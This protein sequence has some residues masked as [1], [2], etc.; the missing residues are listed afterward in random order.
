MK[1]TRNYE[2]WRGD[3]SDQEVFK[4]LEKAKKAFKKYFLLTF[5]PIISIFAIGRAIYCYNNYIFIKTKGRGKGS[6]LVRCW[7]GLGVI[8]NLFIPLIFEKILEN[9]ETRGR[10]VLGFDKL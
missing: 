8:G 7:L 3:A 2:I 10:K 1:T 6:T 9:N 4:M 5:I